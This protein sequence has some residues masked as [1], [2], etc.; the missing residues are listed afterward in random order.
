MVSSTNDA[1]TRRAWAPGMLAAG[2]Y[3]T[4]NTLLVLGSVSLLVAGWM[5]FVVILLILVFG[6]FADELSGEDLDRLGDRGRA[7]Y[8]A[9]LY[10]SLPLMCL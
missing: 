1:P 3:A 8:N 2:Q 4:A 9:N 10:L 5:P 6:S 7:F